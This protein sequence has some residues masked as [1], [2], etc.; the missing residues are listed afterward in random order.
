MFIFYFFS[1]E[2]RKFRTRGEVR[3]Y[4]ENRHDIP[5]SDEVFNFALSGKRGKRRSQI[6]PP[7]PPPPPVEPS[8]AL[9]T[10]TAE[11]SAEEEGGN[12]VV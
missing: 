4:L 9:E 6:Q 10:S 5:Y 12:F 2:G 8:E 3:T 1:P 11:N 7:Q